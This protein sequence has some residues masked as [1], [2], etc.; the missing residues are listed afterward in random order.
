MQE[1]ITLPEFL[2]LVK[3]IERPS[4]MGEQVA[5][6]YY[7]NEKDTNFEDIYLNFIWMV[8]ETGGVSGGSCWDS[9]DPQEYINN[10]EMP[11]FVAFDAVLTKLVPN[12][13]YLHYKVICSQFVKELDYVDNEYYG[14]HTDYEIK[15]VS[16]C[17]LYN[18]LIEHNLLK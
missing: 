12:L 11:E 13:P 10:E 16:L 6:D 15:Y 3:D 1:Q 2:N 9:S 18:Y 17:D 7:S 8:H 5:E 4:E 14:N